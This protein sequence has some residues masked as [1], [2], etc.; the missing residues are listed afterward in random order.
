MGNNIQVIDLVI[1][2]FVLGLIAAWCFILIRP[3]IALVLWAS[4]LSIALYPFF[5]WLKKLLGGRSKLA[6]TVIT[7]LGLGVIIGP[8][9]F[10]AT[11]L[12]SNVQSLADNVASGNLIV[13]P[14]PEGVA[15]WPL[16]GE[17]VNNIWQ[18]AAVNLG[19]V[20]DKFEPQL[21][22][23]TRTLLVLSANTG[24]TL[25]KFIF[26]L[27]IA[28]GL[29][30][31]AEGIS[32]GL[33]SFLTRLSPTQGKTFMQLAEATVRNVTR[34]V[35]GI[36]ILQSL[37]IGIGFTVAGIPAAGLLSLLCLFLSVIQIGPGLVVIATLVYAWSTMSSLSAILFTAWMI[38]AMLIDNVLK[39]ILMASGLSVP[40][41]VILIGVLGGTLTHGIVGLFIGPVIL[42]VGYELIRSWIN[43]T[44][45][46]V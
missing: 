46:S 16:I 3:F 10:I 1:R 37:L 14:P 19:A 13:P 45:V 17:S 44:S 24:L 26:S 7:L 36:A 41:L 43:S 31:N 23:L 40:M 35:I 29:M 5:L 2:I 8:V 9:S 22:E 6:V 12:I 32:R 33:T 30:L 20:L 42:S 11:V 38:P 28:A 27:I 39:P 15:N 4:I 21:R 25:L 34:G 18:Q